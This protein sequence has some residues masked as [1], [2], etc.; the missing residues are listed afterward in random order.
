MPEGDTLFVI[1]RALG[2][3]LDGQRVVSFR[4]TL[5]AQ[6]DRARVGR[7]IERVVARGKNLLVVFDDGWTLHT[8]LRMSGYWRLAPTEAQRRRPP[9]TARVVIEVD[10]W[11]ATCH[12]APVVRMLRGDAEAALG[13]GPDL[14]GETFDEAAAADR[15]HHARELAL[16]EAIVAQ[17]LVAG[18]GNVYKSEV[19]FLE[20]LN[21]FLSAGDVPPE[22]IARVLGR[23]RSLMLANVAPGAR[24][25]TTRGSPR[26]GG[27]GRVWVYR[28]AGEPCFRC[29]ARIAMRRQGDGRSTYFCPE[30]QSVTDAPRMPVAPASPKPR[31]GD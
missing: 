13:L 24:G 25:R 3:R 23:A 17:R 10:R 19:L 8:H 15:V 22:S 21:P 29:G 2:A 4:S 9:P 26:S 20:R 11:V 28:R 7:V 12:R 16:G 31:A 5:G 30:C 27:A 18:I 6:V 14:L 1:A